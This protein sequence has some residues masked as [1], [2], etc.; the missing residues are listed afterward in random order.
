MFPNEKEFSKEIIHSIRIRE[1]F[2]LIIFSLLL[3]ALL[4]N[5][6]FLTVS[7]V[8]EYPLKEA[9][10]WFILILVILFLRSIIIR[11]VMKSRLENDKGVPA[12]FRYLNSFIEISIPSVAILILT[13][14]VEPFAALVSP[15]ILLYFLVIILSTLELDPKFSVLTGLFAAI[16]YIAISFLY[17]EN[18]E[19][20]GSNFLSLSMTYIARANF[21]FIGGIAAAL[22]SSQIKKRVINNYKVMQDRNELEKV[23]GQQISKQIVDELL[24]NKMKIENRSRDASIMF[25]DIRNFSKYCEGKSPE[26]INQY[27]NKVLGFMIDIVN[28]HGGI[29]NQILGDGF[30]AT[31]GAPIRHDNHALSAIN[32]ASEINQS[33]IT[34]I[35]SNE[36]PETK[37]GIGIHSGK[38]VT[39]NVG[40]EDRKQYSVIGNTVNLA[41]RLEQLT[42][43]LD[44][45]IILSKAVVDNSKSNTHNFKSIGEFS[46][47]GFSKP[48]EV[49]KLV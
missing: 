15:P 32:A 5:I 38:V 2:I 25:L 41:A 27:Q 47:K 26:E 20:S 43:E 46:I 37:I 4:F 30:M 6:I 35:N 9:F 13:N 44:S 24:T 17:L 39:G 7:E 12:T 22:V 31:F 28:K 34:K 36:V 1:F 19:N 11:K 45:N 40:T 29:V 33:L 16:Q 21:F 42:K 3:L 8:D 14:Y 23:F 49:Y 48:V 10:Y 18:I